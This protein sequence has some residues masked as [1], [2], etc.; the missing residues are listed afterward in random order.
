M[1]AAIKSV[2]RG[3]TAH[4]PLCALLAGGG[5]PAELMRH[6]L[7]QLQ[8]LLT[9]PAPTARQAFVTSGAMAGMLCAVRQKAGFGGGTQLEA[10][11]SEL[12]AGISALYPADVV[13]YMSTG[14]VA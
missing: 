4:A 8:L 3:C 14:Q 11:L 5:L 1:Q 7:R 10:Q 9:A 13:A 6:V 12:V 2:V